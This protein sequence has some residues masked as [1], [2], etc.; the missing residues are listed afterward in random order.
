MNTDEGYGLGSRGFVPFEGES[1]Y[2]QAAKR[3]AL[4]TPWESRK[5]VLPHESV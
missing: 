3:A 1:E 5:P 2:V 4:Q